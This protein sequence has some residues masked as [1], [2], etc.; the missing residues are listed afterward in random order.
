MR[1]ARVLLIWVA[2]VCLPACEDMSENVHPICEVR[3]P[4]ILMAESVRTASRIPCVRSLQAGWGWGAFRAE[5]GDSTFV[6]SSEA[7]GDTAVSVRLVP[8][9]SI[10][11]ADVERASNGVSVGE[12]VVSD[13]PYVADRTYAFVGGCALVRLAFVGG[14]PVDDLVRD[15]DRTIGFLPRSEIDA[16]LR[17]QGDRGLDPADV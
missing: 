15:V 16:E 1:S 13:D 2:L 7:G 17:S 8:R 12:R 11:R 14:A 9:C 5:N 4:T 6:L 3:P 10:D